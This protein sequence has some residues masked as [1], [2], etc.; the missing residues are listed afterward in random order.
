[1]ARGARRWLLRAGEL[2]LATLGEAH[3][4]HT[5]RP[6]VYPVGRARGM[7]TPV[8]VQHHHPRAGSVTERARGVGRAGAA[9]AAAHFR[10]VAGAARGTADLACLAELAARRAAGGGG[11]V[12]GPVVALFAAPLDD[13]VAAHRPTVG[14]RHLGK[15][16]GHVSGRGEREERPTIVRQDQ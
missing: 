4:P 12:G 2:L 10:H 15:V 6:A 16:A 3:G 5:G 7:H 11:P 13:A 9:R 8:V 14:E 1:R